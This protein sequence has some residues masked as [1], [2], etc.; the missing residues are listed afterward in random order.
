MNFTRS[1][2]RSVIGSARSI[3]DYFGPFGPFWTILDRLDHFQLLRL[4][5]PFRAF[6]TILDYLGPFRTIW[7]PLSHFGR[8]R[9]FLLTD[10]VHRASLG[11]GPSPFSVLKLFDSQSEF[12]DDLLRNSKLE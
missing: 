3:S 1:P 9:L 4:S 11:S 7:N 2:F 12:L 8:F 6:R 5:G 10:S